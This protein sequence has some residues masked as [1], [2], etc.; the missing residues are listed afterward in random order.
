MKNRQSEKTYI[1]K[2]E[3]IINSLQKQKV[4]GLGKFAGE[5]YQIFKE[6]VKPIICNLSQKTE[7]LPNSFY[8]VSS[9]LTLKLDKDITGKKCRPISSHEH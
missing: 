4:T 8:E 9:S 3:S 1:L 5:F 2:I 6:E 7:T